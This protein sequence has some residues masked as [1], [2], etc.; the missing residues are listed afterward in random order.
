MRLLTS[1]RLT[2]AITLLTLASTATGQC[3]TEHWLQSPVNGHWYGVTSTPI[4]WGDGELLAQS[5]GGHLATIRSQA[6]Q[7]WIVSAFSGVVPPNP[8]TGLWI[9][10]YENP[11]QT[12]HWTSGETPGYTSWGAGQPNDPGNTENVCLL[13]AHD[14]F[15]WHDAGDGCCAA[16]SLALIE[17]PKPCGNFGGQQVI[18]AAAAGAEY[19]HVADLDGDSDVDVLSASY[20]DGTVAWYENLGS[21]SFGPQQVIT[22]AALEAE[23]VATAD[24]DGDGDLDVLSA[25]FGDDKVAW[26]ENLGSGAFGPQQ[27]ITTGANGARSVHAA[28]L[29]GDGDADVLSGSFIDD[30]VAWYENQGGGVF[31]QQQVIT[32]SLNGAW[33]VRGVDLDADGDAD[34]LAAGVYADTVAWYENLG[35]GAFGA[36]LVITTSAEDVRSVH[37]VDL[38]GDGDPDVLSASPTDNKVAWYENL[39]S[40]AFGPQQVI[41][42]VADGA[43][44]VFTDDLDGDGDLDVLSASGG[45][46][47][48]AWYENLGSGAFGPQ[49]VIT[50][51]ASGARSVYVADLDGDGDADVLS[52][53]FGDDKI[54]WYENLMGP[55][56]IQSPVN[57]NWYKRTDGAL[58]W[59]DA[60][61]QAQAWGGHLATVRS[62]AENDWLL[63]NFAS[64]GNLYWIGYHDS[65]VEGQFEWSSGEALGYE[66]WRA[67]EPD[68]LNGAD[69]A[70]IAPVTGAW[71]DE[72]FL[73]ERPGIVEVISDDCDGDGQPDAYQ[74]ALEPWLDWNGDGVLDTCAT[75]NYCSTN[76]NSTGAVAVIGASGSP[77]VTANAFTLEAWDLPLNEYGYFLT[78]QS[79]GF[80]P[81]FGGSDGN[82]CLGAPQYRFNDPATGGQVLNS[83]ATGTMS[84]TLDFSLLPNGVTLAPGE[85]WYFQLWFRDVF[86]SN[87]TDGIEVMFR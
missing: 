22:T 3:S 6:E 2:T 42:T 33:P 35:G 54:A 28:D 34:I 86:T 17:A 15:L 40:G 71:L 9:G 58:T 25:S 46:H 61:A 37:A 69:W 14:S 68:D 63:S 52:A 8:N 57:G 44:S 31:G 50:T 47:K 73:P 29:D 70:V 4:T 85:T 16:T 48:V 36:Q 13:N 21:G 55:C 82:L 32:T 1:T 41:T 23:S 11:D 72:T 38:D 18:S 66:N 7:D 26:Y 76:V 65:V 51:D 27:V 19:V 83:G 24:L 67:G 75:S 59:P 79:T 53:S 39:G 30:K 80:V 81:N 20:D 84:L 10:Y 62:Q 49:Q 78:S 87:T 43:H 45:D 12:W 74:I 64:D 60:E 5:M 77:V 56:W